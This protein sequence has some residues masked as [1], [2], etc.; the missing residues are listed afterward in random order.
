MPIFA[1][2]T[3]PWSWESHECIGSPLGPETQE[4]SH[5]FCLHTENPENNNRIRTVVGILSETLKRTSSEYFAAMVGLLH[6]FES[7]L[8]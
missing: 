6:H 4:I 3:N 8:L 7:L 1:R 5:V 2:H